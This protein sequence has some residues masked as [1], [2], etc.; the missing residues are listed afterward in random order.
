MRCRTISQTLTW[1]Q[2]G[3]III[4]GFGYSSFHTSLLN[5]PLGAVEVVAL[6]GIGGASLKLK[7]SRLILQFLCNIPAVIGSALLYSL[8]ASNKVGRL[9]SFYITSTTNASTPMLWSLMSSN[10]A[11]HTK[12]G[13]VN[14][15][16]FAGYCVGFICGPQFFLT[17]EAPLYPTG[18]KTMIVTF[19]IIMLSPGLHWLY[20]TWEDRKRDERAVQ[21]AG[22]DVYVHNEEFL[23]LTDKQQVHFRYTK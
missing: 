19:A 23:D 20:L 22:E 13:M 6:L 9:I 14:M 1:L 8:P 17:K 7:N 16:M 10:I 18:F 15:F 3:S 2:F 12:K 5:M 11:G 21:T 4:K